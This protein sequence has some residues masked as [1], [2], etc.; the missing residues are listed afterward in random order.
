MYVFMHTHKILVIILDSL[1]AIV[2]LK[3]F[4]MWRP[5]PN[6]WP[7]VLSVAH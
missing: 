4:Q 7:A 3:L 2:C 6:H 5:S 1:D